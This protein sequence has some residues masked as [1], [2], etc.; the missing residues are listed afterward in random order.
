MPYT[1]IFIL[2]VE[3]DESL[4]GALDDGAYGASALRCSF[5][6]HVFVVVGY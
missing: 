1:R 4:H 6:E 5:F 2:G 3:V